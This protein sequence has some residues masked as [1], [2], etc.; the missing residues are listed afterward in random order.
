M[1]QT[2]SPSGD[3]RELQ[4]VDAGGIWGRKCT[5]R[6]C[7]GLDR[8]QSRRLDVGFFVVR[9]A[10][11]ALD[12]ME[13]AYDFDSPDGEGVHHAFRSQSTPYPNEDQSYRSSV[14]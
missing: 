4:G 14:V 1:Q 8:L 2:V 5:N 6:Y 3:L 12:G 9:T 10:S 11:I 13:H 7:V